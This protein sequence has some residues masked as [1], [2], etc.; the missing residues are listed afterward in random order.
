MS[1]VIGMLEIQMAADLAILRQN[2]SE[3]KSIVG[4]AASQVTESLELVKKGLELVGVELAADYFKEFIVGAAEATAQLSE[5]SVKSGL[6]VEALTQ[7]RNATTITGTSIDDLVNSSNRMEKALMGANASSSAT[8]VAI[9]QLGLNFEDFVRMS[10]EEQ[11]MAIAKAMAGLEDKSKLGAIAM[12]LYGKSGA[13]QIPTLMLLAEGVTTLGSKTEM[14]T[15]QAKAFIEHLNEMSLVSSAWKSE[16]V[17]GMTPAMDELANKFIEAG[18]GADGLLAHVTAL[19]NDGSIDKW[20]RDGINGLAWLV[21]ALQVVWRT[22]ESVVAV[23]VG[24]VGDIQVI[25]VQLGAAADFF[26]GRWSA[27]S[28]E[29]TTATN[30][31]KASNETLNSRLHEI[32]DGNYFGSAMMVGAA[33]TK[34]ATAEL[35]RFKEAA[36]Q[37]RGSTEEASN[38]VLL[39]SAAT[40]QANQQIKTKLALYDEEIA[41][42][43]A[44]T[45]GEQILLT[46]RQSNAGVVAASVTS[47]AAELDQ[48]QRQAE[49]A[50]AAGT[51]YRSLVD[52]IKLKIAIDQ[53]EISSGVALSDSQKKLL[54]Y[55]QKFPGAS[56]AT[57]S[58][59]MAQQVAMD[60][61]AKSAVDGGKAM[62]E[63][64][65]KLMTLDEG[66]K[67]TITSGDKVNAVQK[68]YND[69]INKLPDSMKEAA[70]AYRDKIQADKDAA[71]AVM[72]H[73]AAIQTII[74]SNYGDIQSIQNAINTQDLQNQQLGKT[75][76]QID[77]LN[78]S[79]VQAMQ[80][81]AQSQ[82]LEAQSIPN[83]EVI[84]SQ[85][86]SKIALY[87]QWA[88]VLQQGVGIAAADAEAKA[89]TKAADTIGTGLTSAF[90]DAVLHGKN[91]F[92]SLRDEVVKLFDQLV[93]TPIIQGVITGTVS[94]ATGGVITSTGTSAIG[95]AAS[96]GIQS[97]YTSLFGGTAAGY[98]AA[99]SYAGSTAGMLGTAGTLDSGYAAY[100]AGTAG[101]LSTADAAAFSGASDVGAADAA[102]GAGE[103]AGMGDLATLGW[104]GAAIAAIYAIYTL[105]ASPGGPKVSGS[106]GDTSHTFSDSH[107]YDQYLQ[108]LVSSTTSSYT[109]LTK[110]LGGQASAHFGYAVSTDPA[111]TADTIVG[112]TVT[113]AAGQTVFDRYAADG[114]RTSADTEAKLADVTSQ[115]MLK[116]LEA[117]NL[118]QRYADFLKQNDTGSLSG[119]DSQ[120]LINTMQQVQALGES[121]G[122]LGGVFTQLSN[123]SVDANLNIVA[124]AGGLDQLKSKT[125]SYVKDYYS[126]SE[127]AGLSSYDMLAALKSVGIDGSSLETKDQ[128]RALVNSL[129]LSTN[130]GQ[131]QLVTLLNMES[132]FST[133]SQF[134]TQNNQTLGQAAATVPGSAVALANAANSASGTS[135]AQS[136]TQLLTT[137][138]DTQTKLLTATQSAWTNQATQMS[139]L[140]DAVAKMGSSVK[141]AVSAAMMTIQP[142]GQE[143]SFPAT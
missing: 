84:I 8:G 122:H 66:Y 86:R 6:S 89:W 20:T 76:E 60:T 133:L 111:G 124:L 142:V 19:V 81:D 15:E 50:L 79:K 12:E 10:P 137:Q 34:E 44:L 1:N 106:A 93:L 53:L 3:M 112:G 121:F 7:F 74:D 83:N 80:A 114:G 54:E 141:D 32:W 134:L 72:A 129:N 49:A 56:A 131:Q 45:A 91:L 40:I 125:S 123:I 30:L 77:A 39:L 42:G 140:I 58:A 69:F 97:A 105:T 94:S 115:M 27:A 17:T 127:Q 95:S 109:D 5:L 51:A 36:D 88:T 25:S 107:V 11:T 9:Q 37:S 96:S 26:A 24:A 128:F 65:N 116:A 103:S 35:Q 101:S 47:G 75:K 98:G 23:G 21:D 64:V 119:A 41:K 102:A 118:D 59:M 120:A 68:A 135:T 13:A 4:E 52:S 62:E 29:M 136:T 100:G 143:V 108:G 18:S 46:A 57:I 117:S 92:A 110:Q 61:Q 73:Q 126:Q 139:T 78:L 87:Q 48:K 43:R 31:F 28:K 130:Q 82:L 2:M 22:I 16:L 85:L 38:T 113:N 67:E 33:S 138:V 63:Y 70:L 99:G 104:I 132:Q 71:D 55:Q 14:Q 90:T